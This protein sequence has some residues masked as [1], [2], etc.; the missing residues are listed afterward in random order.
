MSP[1]E[2]TNGRE[3]GVGE[4]PQSDDGEKAWYSLNPLIL[5]GHLGKWEIL[6]GSDAFAQSFM[7][8]G[9]HRH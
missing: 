5:S 1:F 6:N 2:L 9:G 8:R 7:S 4:E 3:E